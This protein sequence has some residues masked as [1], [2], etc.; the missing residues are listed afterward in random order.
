[1]TNPPR[2]PSPTRLPSDP[3][4]ALAALRPLLV[5]IEGFAAATAELSSSLPSGRESERVQVLA[6]A[7]E[8][9]AKVALESLEAAIGGEQMISWSR[10]PAMPR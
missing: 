4:A 10:P 8:Q 3:A 1:M 5:E 7:S 9:A 6:A 2:E